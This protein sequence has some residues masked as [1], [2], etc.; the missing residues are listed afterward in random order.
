MVWH[1]YAFNSNNHCFYKITE[2]RETVFIYKYIYFFLRNT[3]EKGNPCYIIW[4]REK[5]WTQGC[6]KKI[7]E[8]SKI[9]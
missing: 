8:M 5:K 4:E 1:L 9:Y 6:K 2:V 7:K 3:C